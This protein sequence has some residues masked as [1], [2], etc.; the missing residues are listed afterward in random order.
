MSCRECG[1]REQA[2]ESNRRFFV[3]VTPWM[4]EPFGFAASLALLC[5]AGG[6][7]GAMQ[8]APELSGK[9]SAGAGT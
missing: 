2:P 1:I 4:N 3:H 6:T 9:Y 8:A 5:G 7:C